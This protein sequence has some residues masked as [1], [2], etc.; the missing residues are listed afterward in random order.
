MARRRRQPAPFGQP[1]GGD[2]GLDVPVGPPTLPDIGLPSFGEPEPL[3]VYGGGRP[4]A[5]EP[6]LPEEER[7]SLLENAGSAIGWLGESIGKPGYALRGLAAGEPKAALNLIPFYDTIQ[8][9]IPSL[10]LPEAPKISGE[11]LLSDKWGLMEKPE[12]W[13]TSPE[14]FGRKVA[15]LATEFVDP[16]MLLGGP[17]GSLTSKGAAVAKGLTKVAPEIAEVAKMAKPIEE[18]SKSSRILGRTGAEMAEQV[19]AGERALGGLYLP[20]SKTPIAGLTWNY[21][22]GPERAAKA[23][24][25]LYYNPLTATWRGLFSHVPGVGGNYNAEAQKIAD[26]QFGEAMKITEAM[27][28]L[29][30]VVNSKMAELHGVINQAAKAAAESGDG[31]SFE[32][33][34]EWGRSMLETPGGI[35]KADAIVDSMRKKLGLAANAPIGESLEHTAQ[36][37]ED[38]HSLFDVMRRT[39]DES[40]DRIQALGGTTKD[41]EDAFVAHFGRG[42]TQAVKEAARE[43]GTLAGPSGRFKFWMGRQDWTK[44]MPGGSAA[45]NAIVRDQT[46]MGT[47]LD[48]AGQVVAMAPKDQVA[49]LQ[50]ALTAL[51]ETVDP[52]AKLADLRQQYLMAKHV[53]RGIAEAVEQ[54]HVTQEVA[55]QQLES[56]AKPILKDGKPGA[57][58]SAAF[59]DSIDALPKSVVQTGLY[60]RPLVQDWFEY[61]K[62]AID[63][64]SNLR[65]MHHFLGGE[66]IVKLAGEENLTKLT[67]DGWKPLATVWHDMKLNREGLRTF[68]RKLDPEFAKELDGYAA[69][70]VAAEKTGNK[71]LAKTVA[72]T[73]A[74]KLDERIGA[75]HVEPRTVNALKAFR[76]VVDPRVESTLARNIDKVTNFWKSYLVMSPATWLRNVGSDFFNAL[77]ETPVNPLSLAKNYGKAWNAMRMGKGKWTGPVGKYLDEGELLGVFKGGH[78]FDVMG[79]EPSAL[80]SEGP[81][82]GIGEALKPDSLHYFN[83]L[84]KKFTMWSGERGVRAASGKAIEVGDTLGRAA[85]YVTLREQGMSAAQAAHYV[86]VSHYSHNLAE[87][88]PFEQQVARRAVLFYGWT[89]FNLPLQLRRLAERPGGMT[90]QTLRMMGKGQQVE[91]GQGYTPAFLREGMAMPVAGPPEARTFLRATGLPVEDLNKF[92]FSGGV[93]DLGRTFEKFAAGAHPALALAL[94]RPWMPDARQL[95]SRRK[96]SE[97]ESTTKGL[98]LPEAYPTLDRW[99]KYSP[100]SRQFTDLLSAIDTRKN[101]EQKLANYFTGLKFGT[102]NVPKLEAIDLKN[103]IEDRLADNPLIRESTDYYVPKSK[104]AEKGAEA[105]KRDLRI[106]QGLKKAIEKLRKQQA[107]AQ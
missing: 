85:H 92:I 9:N 39:E 102:Y 77:A 28:N 52:E 33:F 44:N 45:V 62:S 105:A 107:V 41:L 68:A 88:S 67:E 54:G 15:G 60:D 38:F 57:I 74:E 17:M 61:M 24:E 40:L 76:G 20:G 30:P 8:E 35:P 69:A 75:M 49:E 91:P 27:T 97:L 98:G 46:L 6:E 89:R 14:D 50:K 53:R 93:P 29:A 4:A 66:G 100:V 23:I 47:T 34:N 32:A 36:I 26:M 56:W 21:G 25:K 42:A 95:F 106:V 70:G 64:E 31:M 94:E 55:A 80:L 82:G 37:G 13:F 19:R 10:G 83:P 78:I 65:S 2:L 104:K 5:V 1:F 59:L 84:S 18:L 101:T 11:E 81:L 86:K 87:M 48:D 72:D 99:I 22:L 73:I 79:K 90:G 51:G 12:G 71:E 43:R 96:I 103:A 3:P 58:R 63:M 16:L 7:R